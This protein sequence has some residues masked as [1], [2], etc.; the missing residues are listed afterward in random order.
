MGKPASSINGPAF[1]GVP[2]AT[3]THG[4]CLAWRHRS[5][6]FRN[7]APSRHVDWRPAPDAATYPAP[8]KRSGLFNSTTADHSLAGHSPG[9]LSSEGC[10]S[11]ADGKNLTKDLEQLAATPDGETGG[12]SLQRL[13]PILV[14]IVGLIAF[15]AFGLDDYVS[16]DAL[17]AHRERLMSF[18]DQ[19]GVLAGL[20]FMLV[21][22]VAVAFSLPGGAVLT[23]AGGFLFGPWLAASYVLIAATSG[24]TAL[25]L[26]V[27]YALADILRAKAGPWLGKMRDGFNENAFNYLLVLRLIPAFPFFVVNLVPAFLDVSA[28][29][30]VIG[31]ADEIRMSASAAITLPAERGS[32]ETTGSP[33]WSAVPG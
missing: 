24:A 29:T 6:D 5:P 30:Y 1:H 17:H 7:R 2:L 12:F 18:V 26:A 11:A 33:F 27:R 19:N 4:E 3:G 9:L 21:Y 31:G 16:F 20:V 22:A 15:F 10:Q 14:L 28:R 8:C 23:V 25:F 13:W 32:S